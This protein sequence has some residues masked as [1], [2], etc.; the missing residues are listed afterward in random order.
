MKEVSWQKRLEAFPHL[1]S[2]LQIEYVQDNPLICKCGIGYEN[3][4]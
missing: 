1:D 2:M 4:L 3:G